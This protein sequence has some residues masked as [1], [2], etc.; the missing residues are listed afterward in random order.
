MGVILVLTTLFQSAG[1]AVPAFILSL[2]RQ[3][4]VLLLMLIVLS[5]AFGYYGVIYAQAASDL[6]TCLI[7]VIL[8]KGSHVLTSEK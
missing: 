3:G 2:S 7:A 5:A 6:I 8:A 4:V 1:K